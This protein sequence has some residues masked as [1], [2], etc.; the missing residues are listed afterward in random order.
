MSDEE[1]DE[2]EL[3]EMASGAQSLRERGIN[4]GVHFATATAR[5]ILT[6]LEILTPMEQKAFFVMLSTEIE[7]MMSAEEKRTGAATSRPN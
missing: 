4:P 3:E 6:L 1:R 5:S 2:S 7:L